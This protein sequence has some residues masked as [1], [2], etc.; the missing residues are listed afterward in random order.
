[1]Y[2]QTDNRSSKQGEVVMMVVVVVVCAVSVLVM[3]VVA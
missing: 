2:L 1:M 3:A